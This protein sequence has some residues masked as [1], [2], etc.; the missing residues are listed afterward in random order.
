MIVG[1][2]TF[3]LYP[4]VYL[5]VLS[6]SK[7]LLGNPFQ[8][9]VGLDNFRKA[10][11]DEVFIGSLRRSIVFAVPIALIELAAGLGIALLLQG[12][13]RGGHIVR[14][15]ILLPLMTPPIMVASAWKL[16]YYPSG[17]LLNGLLQRVG[18]IDEPVTFL[19]SS[20]WAFPAVGIADAWQWTPFV[21]LLAFATLQSQSEEIEHAAL[22]DGATPW[23]AFRTITLPLIAPALASILLIRLIMAFKIFDLVYSLTFG[24]PGFDT[25]VATFHIYRVALGQFN[26]GYGAAQTLIFGVMVGIVTLPIA[27]LRNWAIRWDQ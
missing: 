15:L 6:A 20:R 9:W 21:A 25:D 27:L 24:G 16:F 8:E 26:V 14:T 17:G 5:L 3:A 2:L 4:F 23:I 7:S 11:D 10:F 12:S 1:L 22:V 19:G 18:L 13:L